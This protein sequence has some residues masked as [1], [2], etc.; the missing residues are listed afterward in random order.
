[1]ISS[2]SWVP[3]SAV[4]E[5]PKKYTLTEEEYKRVMAMTTSKAE[6]ARN[7]MQLEL[8]QMTIDHGDGTT[9]D[10]E[11]VDA[12]YDMANYDDDEKEQKENG[13]TVEQDTEE[14]NDE[15]KEALLSKVEDLIEMDEENQD[16]DTVEQ[17]E[18]SDVEDMTLRAGDRVL[19]CGRTEDDVS[20]LDMYV[21]DEADEHNLYVHH[22]IMLPSFP[23]SVQP[24]N[25]S[26]VKESS[27]KNFV[28]VGSFEPDIEIW[29]MD[30][31]DVACP[32]AILKGH[33]DAVMSL[34]WN[35]TIPNVMASGSADKNIIIWNLDFANEPDKAI[36]KKIKAHKDKVQSVQ[37]NLVEPHLLA[38]A[39]YDKTIGLIDARSFTHSTVLSKLS[40]DPEC[41][42]WNPHIPTEL[43]CS[44]ESGCVSVVDIRNPEKLVK[45]IEAHG[46]A[47]SAIDLH[48]VVPG[49][50]LTAS[51]DRSLK[52][53]DV[54]DKASCLITREPDVGKLFTASFSTD[55]PFVV[56][57]A[58]SRGELKVVNLDNSDSYRDFI[59][60]RLAA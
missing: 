27:D 12:K 56:A 2:L 51:V 38:S 4:S 26:M 19:V 33:K 46:K 57:C 44:D 7:Q 28:A 36:V 29:N 21:Y 14:P 15:Y 1:M 37:W 6:E 35:K 52:V 31:L 11:D 18:E 17:D 34:S 22:D 45:K 39:S 16:G 10:D 9:K 50:L 59:K 32:T 54:S 40:E 49:L 53:W 8:S 24:I 60:T 55:S 23:L 48:P 58:G 5:K 43:Y 41:I 42:R 20:Y 13:E 47:C 3:V 25:Y 30:V